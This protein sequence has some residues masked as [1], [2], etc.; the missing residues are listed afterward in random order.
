MRV[1]P[2]SIVGALHSMPVQ[3]M[4][5]VMDHSHSRS[6][7]RLFEAPHPGLNDEKRS[8]QRLLGEHRFIETDASRCDEQMVEIGPA[9]GAAG[10][11]LHRQLQALERRSIRRE[12]ANAAA[13]PERYPETA[14]R[15]GRHAIGETLA[16]IKAQECLAR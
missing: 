9:K 6:K 13:V 14:L 11:T 10:R 16:F 3:N 8:R 12:A 15:I 4:K 5:F 7:E 1:R 2:L